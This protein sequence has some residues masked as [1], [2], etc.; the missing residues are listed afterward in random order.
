MSLLLLVVSPVSISPKALLG[1]SIALKDRS[2][3]L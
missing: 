2:P 1:S 3:M